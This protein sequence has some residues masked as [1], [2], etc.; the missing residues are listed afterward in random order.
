[1]GVWKGRERGGRGGILVEENCRRKT[2]LSWTFGNTGRRW[3][4]VAGVKCFV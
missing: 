4:G 2:V 3:G 1:V